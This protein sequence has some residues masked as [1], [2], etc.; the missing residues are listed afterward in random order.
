MGVPLTAPQPAVDLSGDPRRRRRERAMG[1]VFRG[2][3]LAGNGPA[4][5]SNGFQAAI[6][7]DFTTFFEFQESN[8]R[9]DPLDFATGEELCDPL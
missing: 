9:G 3:A 8:S 1:L 5:L 7:T 6:R 2:A 4:K